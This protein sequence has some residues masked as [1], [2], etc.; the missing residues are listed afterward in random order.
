VYK[1]KDVPCVMKQRLR[2]LKRGGVFF[3]K[4]KFLCMNERRAHKEV[5]S[6]TKTTELKNLGT[7]LYKLTFKWEKQAERT[8]QSLEEV[9]DDAL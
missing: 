1:K 9:R 6:S 4:D 8:V 5:I 2:R 3:Y 7:C